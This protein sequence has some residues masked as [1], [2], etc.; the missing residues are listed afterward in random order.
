[1]PSCQESGQVPSS[2]AVLHLWFGAA[3]SSGVAWGKW[4]CSEASKPTGRIWTMNGPNPPY[5]A[6]AKAEMWHFLNVR[7][8]SFNAQR[9]SRQ[10]LAVQLG[11]RSLPAPLWL[12]HRCFLVL[13]GTECARPRQEG[14]AHSRLTI[15]ICENNVGALPAQL[16]SHPLQVTPSCCFLDQLP[17]LKGKGE[18]VSTHSPASGISGSQQRRQLQ[19]PGQ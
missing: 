2:S 5:R 15:R 13:T 17:N 14:C 1:M 12:T 3:G 9:S 10:P 6:A 19:S 18:A 7:A 11:L 4:L 16:Q 8:S